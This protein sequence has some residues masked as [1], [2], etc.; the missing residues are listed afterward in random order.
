LEARLEFGG[1]VTGMTAAVRRHSIAGMR[2]CADHAFF[3]E[4]DCGQAS[5]PG[6]RLTITRSVTGAK[7]TQTRLI[8]V[9]HS[10]RQT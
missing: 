3:S 8:I 4:V 5:F 2:L 7:S 10:W 6:R 1:D 9:T